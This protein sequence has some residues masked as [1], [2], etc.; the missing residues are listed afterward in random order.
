MFGKIRHYYTEVK[1][2]LQKSTWPKWTEVKNTTVVV[3]ITVFIFSGFLYLCD[4]VLSYS[5]SAMN[6]FFTGLLR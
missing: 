2:E 5:V 3:I 4:M 1:G 6:D